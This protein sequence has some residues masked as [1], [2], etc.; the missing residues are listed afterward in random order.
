MLRERAAFR[1]LLKQIGAHGIVV[2]AGTPGQFVGAAGA[3]KRGIY[4]LHTY[5]HGRR[6]E[7]L[8]RWLMH[9]FFRR[10]HRLVAVSHFQRR[11]MARLWRMG[12]RMNDIVVIPNTAGPII[13]ALT[14]APAQTL[15]VIT[16]SWLEPYKQPL[17]WLDVATAVA[18]RL[19]REHVRFTW[20]G[21]GSMLELCRKAAQDRFHEVDANFVGHSDDVESGYRKASLYLQLSSTENMSLSVIDA[22]RFGVPAVA[23]AVGGLPEIVDDGST[24]LL[25]PVHDVD[26][27]ATAVSRL[28]SDTSLR[29]SMVKASR[30]RYSEHFGPEKW[31]ESMT[32][33]HDDIFGH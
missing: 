5:P 13:P 31:Y 22:L 33:L 7:F 26:A 19:G 32:A 1:Q 4:I 28:L 6:Q 17:E 27:A 9:M 16:A 12:S 30:E 14:P 2:T 29:E 11:A 10:V 20:L 23:T 18:Q 25:V 21:E 8:G 3:S 24:G 15:E